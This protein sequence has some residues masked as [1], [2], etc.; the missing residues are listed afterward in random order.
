MP[1]ITRVQMLNQKEQSTLSIRRNTKM[2]DLPMVIGESIGKVAS[3]LNEIG[4]LMADVPFVAYHNFDMLNLDVEIGFPVAMPL[5]GK[6]DVQQSII[7]AGKSIAC[8]YL[9]P[10][11]EMEPV[12]EEMT[13]WITDN[14]FQPNSTVYEYYYNDPEFPESEWLTKIVMPI[15]SFNEKH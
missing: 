4:E 9:G 15:L 2:E 8:M 3:Y 6:G 5:P 1:K 14:D 13:Q 7:P 12:Y 10:Y 11:T